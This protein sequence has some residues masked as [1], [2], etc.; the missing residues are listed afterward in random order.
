MKKLVLLLASV[1]LVLSLSGTGMAALLY[2]GSEYQVVNSSLTWDEA[3]AGATALGSGWHLVTITSQGE[4][5]FIAGLLGSQNGLFWAGASQ[6]A[7]AGGT[8][9]GWSWVTGETWDYTSWAPSTIGQPISEPNDWS[10][11]DEIYLAVDGRWDRNWRWND[12]LTTDGVLGYVAERTASVPEPATLLLLG[13]GLVGLV[14]YR[15]RK[16]MM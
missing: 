3:N 5:D 1:F 14:G 12:G 16:R 13:S 6:A 15:R 11:I 4:Q 2:G 8:A 10:G 9:L 7:G